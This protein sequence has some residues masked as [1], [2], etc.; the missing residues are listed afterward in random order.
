LFGQK[1]VAHRGAG[2]HFLQ[3]IPNAHLEIRAANI[4]G[5]VQRLVGVLN[6]V[7][8]FRYQSGIVVLVDLNCMVRAKSVFEVD[9]NMIWSLG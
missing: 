1:G 5:Q 3:G 8:D 6:Q 4:E 7:H 2:G 9:V